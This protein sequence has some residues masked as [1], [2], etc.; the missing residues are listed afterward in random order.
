M[1][2]LLLLM[3]VVAIGI[4]WWLGRRYQHQQQQ[5]SIADESYYKGLN[6]LLNHQTDEALAVFI[7][8]LEVNNNNL[9]THLALGSAFRR[10][11]DGLVERP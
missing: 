8:S 10:K 11:G 7:D 5:A 1:D 6:Y 2:L 4:G 3:L 9:D